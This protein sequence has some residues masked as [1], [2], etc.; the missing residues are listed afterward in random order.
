MWRKNIGVILGDITEP[1][2][3]VRTVKPA[4]EPRACN[5]F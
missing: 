5:D 2:S 3:L 1:G 4:P